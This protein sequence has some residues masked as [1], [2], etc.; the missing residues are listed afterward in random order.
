LARFSESRQADPRPSLG[1]EANVK[2]NM[3]L[4]VSGLAI[5]V[6]SLAL[7][8]QASALTTTDTNFLGSV[9]PGV[10]SSPAD[11][12]GYIN[13]LIGLAPT[14]WTEDPTTGVDLVSGGQTYDRAT[15]TC[16]PAASCP[17]ATGTGAVKDESGANS[18]TLTGSFSYLVAK[19]DQD[20]A[21]SLI[22]YIGGVTGTYTVP[23]SFNGHGVSHISAYGPGTGAPQTGGGSGPPGGGTPEPASLA[24]FG[25]GLL[26]AGYRFRRRTV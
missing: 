20:Q 21:G 25:L 4:L 9:T 1:E 3:R 17:T 14:A 26:G 24:L 2:R 15:G 10:P 22:W 19:Y 13:T 5:C 8:S 18:I 16:A 23:T 7:A 6:A 11:E 12:V